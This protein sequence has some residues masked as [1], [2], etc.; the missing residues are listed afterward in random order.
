MKL[1]FS[2]SRH[3]Q[4]QRAAL[5]K[6]LAVLIDQGKVSVWSD[7]HLKPGDE[8]QKEIQ[9]QLQSVD[10]FVVLLSQSYFSSDYCMKIEAPYAI[11]RARNARKHLVPVLLNHCSWSQT[12]LKDFQ[13]VP[14]RARPIS[15]FANRDE[16]TQIF[17]EAINAIV[18]PRFRPQWLVDNIGSALQSARDRLKLSGASFDVR[19]VAVLA[20]STIA[21][22]EWFRGRDA[23]TVL[24]EALGLKP[25]SGTPHSNDSQ[26]PVTQPNH[27]VGPIVDPLP[28]V[29]KIAGLD[30]EPRDP[31]S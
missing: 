18:D 2:Y 21:V 23:Q 22:S 8:W 11:N 1:M 30:D 13:I 6:A 10:I 29:L 16:A 3:D 26:S 28:D 4:E 20:T 19:D 25:E 7:A 9:K 17:A 14:P 24:K 27:S 5:E 31:D 15:E 12:E